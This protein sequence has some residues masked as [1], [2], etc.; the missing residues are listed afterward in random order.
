MDGARLT[1]PAAGAV[2][3]WR[4]P[5][6]AAAVAGYLDAEEQRR[7]AALTRVADRLAFTVRRGAQ[8]VILAAYLGCTP[9][10][11]RLVR[12]PQGKPRLAG[13]AAHLHFNAT[14]RGD[15]A[16]L[17]VAC[18]RAVGIDVEIVRPLPDLDALIRGLCTPQ[19]Q[20]ALQP[21]D[22][23]ARNA[24][25]YR[26]WTG[27]EAYLKLHGW[28]LAVEPNTVGVD[29]ADV[30]NSPTAWVGGGPVTGRAHL[31]WLPVAPGHVAALAVVGAPPC[32]RVLDFTTPPSGPGV[33]S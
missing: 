20:A 14:R 18:D 3:V 19:E 26:L 9:E 1:T 15:L 22:P 23:A 27:K 17:A 2:D 5:A 21:L 12:D 25:F 28:G 30:L 24:A 29:A 4:I 32:I 8:R 11:V 13:D 31:T 33:A 10:D 7:A 16:L 6:A